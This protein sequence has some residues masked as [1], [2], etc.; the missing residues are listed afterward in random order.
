MLIGIAVLLRTTVASVLAL[1][2]WWKLF[3]R[4]SFAHAFAGFAPTKF[5]RF[6]NE[7]VLPLAAVE[8][9]L[10]ASLLVGLISPQVRFAAPLASLALVTV[11]SV[12][13]ARAKDADECGCWT[14]PF[15]SDS[16][17]AR[18]L[19][20]VRNALLLMMLMIVAALPAGVTG[21]LA[22]AVPAGIVLAAMTVELP[23]LVAVSTYRRVGM[24][25]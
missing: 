6:G 3:H 19:L 15:V 11:F 1:S 13:V 2:A 21:A 18:R 5:R 22:T 25:R 20:L 14:M 7:A 10:A 8:L 9:V 4:R 12:F 24:V 16:R 23:Q 17:R